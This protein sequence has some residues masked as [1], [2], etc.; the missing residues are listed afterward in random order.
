MPETD[1]HHMVAQPPQP[2]LLLFVA[3]ALPA[4]GS[5]IVGGGAGGSRGPAEARVCVDRHQV[6]FS[7]L[8]GRTSADTFSHPSTRSG[9]EASVVEPQRLWNVLWLHKSPHAA[10]N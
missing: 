7:L 3:S 6:C 5:H 10:A 2:K 8:T 1:Q 4:V 9:D